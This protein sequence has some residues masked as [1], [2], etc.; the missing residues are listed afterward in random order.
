MDVGL[1]IEGYIPETI[2]EKAKDIVN[3]LS[4]IEFELKIKEMILKRLVYTRTDTEYVSYYLVLI[5][6]KSRYHE[7]E[8][9]KD[10]QNRMFSLVKVS[11]FMYKPEG[12]LD[13]HI[14]FDTIKLTLDL[15]NRIDILEQRFHDI[16]FHP[17]MPGGQGQKEKAMQRINVPSPLKA[18]FAALINFHVFRIFIQFNKRKRSLYIILNQKWRVF[19]LKLG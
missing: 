4:C 10:F 17:S 6:N 16:W 1:I 3:R 14:P 18:L 5:S 15:Q 19:Q 2:L 9:E 13:I 8:K 11:N 12:G 7:K